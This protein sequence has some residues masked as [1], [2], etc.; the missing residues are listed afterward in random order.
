MNRQVS[1]TTE[2]LYNHSNSTFMSDH[3]SSELRHLKFVT[4]QQ[5]TCSPS[6][7]HCYKSNHYCLLKQGW[8]V[9]EQVQQLSQSC[10]TFEGKLLDILC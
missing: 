4:P 1:G 8:I 5:N 6:F 7:V 9:D 10:K 2:G 3:H